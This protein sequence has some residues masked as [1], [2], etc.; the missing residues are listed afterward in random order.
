[1]SEVVRPT[2][3]IQLPIALAD[4]KKS[5]MVS[6]EDFEKWLQRF[7]WTYHQLSRG[8]FPAGYKSLDEFQ[9]H[10]ICSDPV[11]WADAFLRDPDNPD[12]PY[13]LW[14]YQR[15]SIRYKGHTL[16]ECGA[17]VGKTREI[18][19]KLM[20]AAFTVARGS[21]LVGAPQLTH[22]TEIIDMIEEQLDFNPDLKSSLV[23][24]EKHPHHKMKFSNKF[25]IYFRPAGFEG[26]AFRSVHVKTLALMDE[27]AKAKNPAI[28]KEFWRAAKPGCAYKLYSTPD[29]DRSCEFYRLCAKATGSLNEE[30]ENDVGPKNITF[31]K[32]QWGKPLMPAPF[33]TQQRRREFIDLYHGED[34]PGYQQNV[35]GNWGDPENSVFPWHQFSKL[36]KAIPEYRVLKILND[37]SQSQVSIFGAEYKPIIQDGAR[38]EAEEIIIT[39]RQIST[40]MFDI[41]AE[42]KSF[43]ASSPGLHYGGCDLGYSIDPTEI[44]I[45]LIIGR[46][47]RTIARLQL[48]G[49]TYDQQADA[50]D[51]LDDIFDSYR[52]EMGWGLDFGNAGSAVCHILHNQDQYAAKGY[53]DRLTGYQFGGTYEAVNEE[54][55]L[56]IDAHTKKPIKL[57]G[58]ELA[59]D[60]LVTK[61]QRIQLEYPPDP[62]IMLYYPSH[63]FRA[64]S[65]HR[66]FK[67]DDD[68]LIDA[69]RVLTLKVVLEADG[70]EDLFA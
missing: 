60:L 37:E 69:D 51:A 27:A 48:K 29:G 9:L 23:K 22:L 8:E 28:F 43:F 41:K 14:G 53:E 57:T 2:N 15:E 39:D 64:G 42:I 13:T 33:W 5:I 50:I 47:H 38:G 19:V 35:L 21:A 70:S 32:F 63:T 54:G 1:M 24:H 17:E 68:H 18:L 26:T 4:L 59:T 12:K 16:H 55:D 46:T 30:D 66:I 20:H 49:V 67:K 11:L 3:D 56:I 58:K 45:K 7:D 34:S 62:D 44:L 36:I 61:M 40:G 31:K 10:C 65:R 52:S 25:N 6:R